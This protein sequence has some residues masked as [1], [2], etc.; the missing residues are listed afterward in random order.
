MSLD[1]IRVCPSSDALIVRGV[2][3]WAATLTVRQRAELN[4]EM[5][6]LTD[7]EIGEFV[8]SDPEA[9]RTVNAF[10]RHQRDN[11]SG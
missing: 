11:W 1:D 8:R 5:A 3:D 6:D 4:A 9:R 10:L 7:E 2:E